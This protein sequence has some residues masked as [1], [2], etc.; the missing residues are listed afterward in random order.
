MSVF[1]Q[2]L[3]ATAFDAARLEESL[4]TSLSIPSQ[5]VNPVVYAGKV[6][7]PGLKARVAEV[8]NKKFNENSR[9]ILNGLSSLHASKTMHLCREYS[10]T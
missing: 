10:N 1:L 2:P 9:L 3:L 8:N 4:I 7:F 6:R 5:S